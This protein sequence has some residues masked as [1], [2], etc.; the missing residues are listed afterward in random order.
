MLHDEGFTCGSL[1]NESGHTFSLGFAAKLANTPDA[2]G[3][4]SRYITC[5][6]LCHKSRREAILP[7]TQN[8]TLV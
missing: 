3:K 8:S 5:G 6:L 1:C 4:H 7:S 2:I